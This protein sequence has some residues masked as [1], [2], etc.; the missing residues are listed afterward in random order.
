MKKQVKVLSVK[1]FIWLG[2]IFAIVAVALFFVKLVQKDPMPLVLFAFA[3]L[4]CFSLAIVRNKIN[5]RHGVKGKKLGIRFNIKLDKGL[6]KILIPFMLGIVLLELSIS[7]FLTA[8]GLS[9]TGLY[10][11]LSAITSFYVANLEARIIKLQKK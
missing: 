11:L 2:I 7:Y 1:K 6:M 9:S 5:R 4:T 10:I 3:S 8:K